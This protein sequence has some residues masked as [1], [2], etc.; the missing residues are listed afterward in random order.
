MVT[1]TGAAWSL[2][3]ALA[4]S[5]LLVGGLWGGGVLS[6]CCS[7]TPQS[8]AHPQRAL[9]RER[10][11]RAS[12]STAP[13]GPGAK[14]GPRRSLH[15]HTSTTVSWDRAYP[16]PRGPDLTWGPLYPRPLHHTHPPGH[17]TSRET[18]AGRRLSPVVPLPSPTPFIL[19]TP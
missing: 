12:V 17:T 8:G 1:A 13:A 5:S 3:C 10:G 2:R 18:E 11:Q 4:E 14:A 9:A 6:A 16:A 15:Q 7:A 19:P